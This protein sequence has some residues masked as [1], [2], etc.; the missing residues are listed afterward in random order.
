MD[1]YK[2]NFSTQNVT[3]AFK[4]LYTKP[5]DASVVYQVLT[6]PK[7]SCMVRTDFN[8]G[9]VEPT[10]VVIGTEDPIIKAGANAKFTSIS[11]VNRIELSNLDQAAVNKLTAG[12]TIQVF[13]HPRNSGTFAINS[14]SA[15]SSTGVTLTVA[16]TVWPSDF[17]VVNLFGARVDVY[18]GVSTWAQVNKPGRTISIVQAGTT[19]LTFKPEDVYN[20]NGDFNALTNS[21]IAGLY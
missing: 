6:L 8:T 3:G 9:A 5:D 12:S 15:A 16:E 11:S 18:G 10:R 14:I 2:I 13:N 1:A 17:Q 20:Y 4:I 21:V 7:G 19:V